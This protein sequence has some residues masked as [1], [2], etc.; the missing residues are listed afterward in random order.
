MV[1]FHI[2]RHVTVIHV[3]EK[4]SS[5]LALALLSDCLLL[6]CNYFQ[7]IC[8]AGIHT[9]CDVYLAAPVPTPCLTLLSIMIAYK[10]C[11][12]VQVC[13][14]FI[15]MASHTPLWTQELTAMLEMYCHIIL[16]CKRKL[17]GSVYF[18]AVV[19]HL[20]C[21]AALHGCLTGV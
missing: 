3:T 17:C 8:V 5:C 13:M 14:V 9:A 18:F 2:Q 4:L 1:T 16:F 21:S 19:L 20:L 11:P 15:S 6:I 7:A 10:L 12:A